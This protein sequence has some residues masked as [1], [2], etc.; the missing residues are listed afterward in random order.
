MDAEKRRLGYRE[1]V[2]SS[3]LNTVLFGLKFWVGTAVGSVAMIADA[4]H[5]LSDTLTSLVV[6]LGFWI[7]S[8]P[9][10][11]EHPFGHGRAELIASV[12]IGTL[13]GV[14]GLNFLKESW[15]QLG[16]H[17]AVEYSTISIIVFG[18]SVAGKEALRGIRSGRAGR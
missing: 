3:V 2:I 13:L 18:I 5:T 14:V 6:I 17:Q 16:E 7:S 1:G 11:D 9:K 8:K 10:D 15:N 4:W 12:I